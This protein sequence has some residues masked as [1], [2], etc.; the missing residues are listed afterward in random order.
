MAKAP[1]WGGFFERL[2]GIMKQIGRALL[3]FDE[4]KDAFMDVETFINNNPLTYMGEEAEQQVLTPKILTKGTQ[5][6][7]LKRTWIKYTT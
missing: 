4:L 3:T 6:H 1:W 5:P 7:S 2:I